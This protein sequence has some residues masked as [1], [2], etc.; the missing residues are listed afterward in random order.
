MRL[1]V[2][3]RA[4]RGRKWKFAYFIAENFLYGVTHRYCR[5]CHKRK[6]GAFTHARCFT[7]QMDNLRRALEVEP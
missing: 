6:I 4:L 2:F 1:R 3:L 5:Q 7:C